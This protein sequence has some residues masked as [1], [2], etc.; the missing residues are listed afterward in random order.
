MYKSLKQPRFLLRELYIRSLR[1][2][3]V[4]SALVAIVNPGI[5]FDLKLYSLLFLLLPLLRFFC[6][7]SC[8]C[9]RQC[10]YCPYSEFCCD[11]VGTVVAIGPLF[12][13]LVRPLVYRIACALSLFLFIL[14]D[15]S[16]PCA[17]CR[18]IIQS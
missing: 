17:N 3:C 15:I 6:D 14:L 9:S 12:D 4:P 13:L 8:G 1:Q 11:F 7:F 10:Y 18:K 2:C 16:W 5:S